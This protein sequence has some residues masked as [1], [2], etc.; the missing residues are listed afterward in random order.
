MTYQYMDFNPSEQNKITELRE[1]GLY[2]YHLRD[3]QPN[4]FTIE[5][6]VWANRIGFLITD[7]D[8]LKDKEFITSYEFADMHGTEGVL[9]E[10]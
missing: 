5:H 7:V 8:I 3:I 2:V 4:G 1:R 9:Y 6:K 10:R